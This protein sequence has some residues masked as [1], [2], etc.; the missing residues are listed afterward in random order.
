MFITITS[1][2][3]ILIEKPCILTIITWNHL[4]I[5]MF[6]VKGYIHACMHAPFQA[7]SSKFVL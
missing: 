5:C 1:Y 2:C 3:V 4:R 7:D 6:D